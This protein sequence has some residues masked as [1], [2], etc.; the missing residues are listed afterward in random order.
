MGV[1]NYLRTE[2]DSSWKGHEDF[3][4]WLVNELKPSVIV[5]LGVD[6]GFST[7]VFASPGIGKVYG[8]DLFQNPYRDAYTQALKH[9]EIL[10]DKFGISNVEIIRGWFSDIVRKW[11]RPIDILHIDGSHNYEDVKR[12]Y[13]EWSKFVKKNGVILFHDVNAPEY[14]GFGVRKFFD[15]IDLPKIMFTH[16]YGLGVV[17]QNKDLMK[18]IKE[19]ILSDKHPKFN[20][21]VVTSIVGNQDRIRDKQYTDGT[22][23]IAFTDQES[24][25]WHVKK[26]CDLFQDPVRNAKIHKVLIHKYVDANYSLWMD[27]NYSLRTRLDTL[28]KNWLKGYDMAVFNHPGRDCIYEEA[29]KCYELQKGDLDRVEEQEMQYHKEGYPR[30]NGLVQCTVILRKHSKEMERFNEA[31][32][33]EIC[34]YSNRDQISFPKIIKNF[35][36]KVNV[37]RGKGYAENHP[38]FNWV[39]HLN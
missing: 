21:C 28:I 7:F 31:W 25:T 29:V 17:S 12:D 26:P 1:L 35:N 2:I 33:A 13:E 16:S 18:K 20:S 14:K 15:E 19:K 34:R 5:D 4:V 11:E 38:Y 10:K 32:W 27:G 6:F 22:N 37:L 24:K 9:Q 30:H 8:M 3:A 36:L 23:F 39:S